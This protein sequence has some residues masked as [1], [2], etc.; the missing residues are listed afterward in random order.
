MSE[1][2]VL[3]FADEADATKMRDKLL[4]LK[5]VIR[6]IDAVFVVRKQEGKMIV[7]HEAKLAS[8][9]EANDIYQGLLLG[10][11]YWMSWQEIAASTSNP[12]RSYIGL[13]DRFVKEACRIME[14]SRAVLFLLVADSP[15]NK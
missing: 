14:I 9:S 6:L 7:K 15:E 11:S 3:A 2:I 5:K 12:L 10:F 8:K 1:L 13:D 4:K